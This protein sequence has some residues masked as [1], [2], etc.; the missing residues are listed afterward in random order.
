[1]QTR[2]TIF[3]D[4]CENGGHK[5]FPFQLKNVRTTL[6]MKMSSSPCS[7]ESAAYAHAQVKG[8]WAA[9]GSFAQTWLTPD[10]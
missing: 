8:R 6:Q 2:D 3:Q 7:Q 1:M 5:I 9:L 4:G 10:E